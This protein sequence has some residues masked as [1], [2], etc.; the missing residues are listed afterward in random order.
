MSMLS[1]WIDIDH[2]AMRI[3]DGSDPEI[4]ANRVAFIE[5]TPRVRIAPF[6][7]W[8][9]DY[10]NW[11]PGPKGDGQLCGRDLKSRAWCDHQLILLG[12]TLPEKSK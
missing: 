4:I 2:C 6:T 3:I 8:A 7:D 1:P 10:T 11:S 9:T 5:K 12:Y